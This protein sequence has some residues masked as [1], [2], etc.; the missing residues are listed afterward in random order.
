M[1]LQTIHVGHANPVNVVENAKRK[2]K[3]LTDAQVAYSGMTRSGVSAVIGGVASLIVAISTIAVM[4]I[5]SD[6]AREIVTMNSINVCYA[7]VVALGAY[8]V[9]GLVPV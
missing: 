6:Q 1:V 4:G 2:I 5:V 9:E 7:F 8:L 3:S